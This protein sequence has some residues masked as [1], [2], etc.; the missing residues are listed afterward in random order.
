MIRTIKLSILLCWLQAEIV[1]MLRNM[2]QNILNA[3]K[4]NKNTVGNIFVYFYYKVEV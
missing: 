3:I 1:C 2:Y 4:V